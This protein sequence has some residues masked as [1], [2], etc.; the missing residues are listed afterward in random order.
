[1]SGKMISFSFTIPKKDLLAHVQ[2]TP[3]AP[4]PT[5]PEYLIVDQSGQNCTGTFK[6]GAGAGNDQ[7]NVKGEASTSWG[8]DNEQPEMGAPVVKA[9]PNFNHNDSGF[10]DTQSASPVIKAEP[11]LE[12][13]VGAPAMNPSM[14]SVNI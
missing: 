12:L 3:G 5:S 10:S 6:M 9:E 13:P 14:T 11:G 8:V 7:V 4:T 1:M 2:Q